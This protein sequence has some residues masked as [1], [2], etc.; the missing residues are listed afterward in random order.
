MNG[1]PGHLHELFSLNGADDAGIGVLWW[2]RNMNQQRG[3][4][5]NI[6]SLPSLCDQPSITSPTHQLSPSYFLSMRPRPAL[7]HVYTHL[8][9][10]VSF[11]TTM[12]VI[13]ALPI[14]WALTVNDVAS[15]TSSCFPRSQVRSEMSRSSPH[16]HIIR[17]PTAGF[18]SSQELSCLSPHTQ[19]GTLS[20]RLETEVEYICISI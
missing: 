9:L 18:Y 10:S 2:K 14:E 11:C 4:F 15:L 13:S 5:T 8:P 7:Q 20:N 19:E 12:C 16:Y 6:S 17:P 3:A 1:R